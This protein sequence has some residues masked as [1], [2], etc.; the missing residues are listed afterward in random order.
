MIAVVVRAYR[1]GANRFP[2]T[3]WNSFW[4]IETRWRTGPKP[5]AA[6]CR[7]FRGAEGWRYEKTCLGLEPGERRELLQAGRPHVIR[8]NVDREAEVAWTDLV[9]GPQGRGGAQC[10]L[11]RASIALGDSELQKPIAKLS[12]FI[13]VCNSIAPERPDPQKHSVKLALV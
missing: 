11:L 7:T 10:S 13:E 1:R 3:R 6:F 8:F 2:S 4:T 5:S 9:Y 12:V